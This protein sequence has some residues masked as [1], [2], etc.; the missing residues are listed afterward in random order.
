LPDLVVSCCGELI[1][2][3]GMHGCLAIQVFVAALTGR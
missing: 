1:K 2:K 3:V